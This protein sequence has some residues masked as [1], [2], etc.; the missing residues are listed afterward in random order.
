MSTS[1][2]QVPTVATDQRPWTR[3]ADEQWGG[4]A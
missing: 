3:T 2:A 1:L 4:G